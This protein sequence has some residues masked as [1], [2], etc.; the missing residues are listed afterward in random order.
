RERAVHR[1]AFGCHHRATLVPLPQ[2]PRLPRLTLSKKYPSKSFV[3]IFC[4][5]SP[6]Q[7]LRGL[8][9]CRKRIL[10]NHNSRFIGGCCLADITH[11]KINVPQGSVISNEDELIGSGC[12]EITSRCK[13][14]KRHSRIVAFCL[15]IRQSDFR[16]KPE[17]LS[18]GLSRCFLEQR[19]RFL[20]CFL[21]GGI[22]I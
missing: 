9:K 18:S 16:S 8:V 17:F 4:R 22:L 15:N 3:Q 5:R 1:Q 13:S 19:I 7:A 14:R 10:R 20:Y 11:L 12:N 21:C 6:L 2:F